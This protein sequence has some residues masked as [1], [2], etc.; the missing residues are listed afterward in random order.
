[1]PAANHR[2]ACCRRTSI[3]RKSRRGATWLA[4]PPWYDVA[5]SESSLY[6]AR[7]SKQDR[8]PRT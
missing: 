8:I 4:M 2:A 1:L 3:A 6:Y 5:D 7:L